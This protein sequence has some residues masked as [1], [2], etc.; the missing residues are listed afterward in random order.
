MPMPR[1]RRMSTAH[2]EHLGGELCV[3]DWDRHQ[4]H[5]LN[6]ITAAVWELCD[7]RTTPG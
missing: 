7:G 1:P 3:Y 5:A 2:V 6:P 4:V